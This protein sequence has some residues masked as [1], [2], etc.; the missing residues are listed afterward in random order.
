M[1]SELHPPFLSSVG[2]SALFF[3]PLRYLFRPSTLVI[4]RG[5]AADARGGIRT[6]A[7][8]KEEDDE[9]EEG[10][11]GEGKKKKKRRLR[12]SRI[13]NTIVSP[14]SSGFASTFAAG[15]VMR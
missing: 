4:Y 3:F 1:Q 15:E 2:Y 6:A 9:E 12:G 8:D 14:R 7:R 11:R 13:R 5:Y 10:R